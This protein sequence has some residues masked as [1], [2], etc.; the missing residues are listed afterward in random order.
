MGGFGNSIYNDFY[1]LELNYYK[2]TKYPP[3]FGRYGHT[4]TVAAGCI[5]V[6]GGE[7]IINRAK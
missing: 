6:I 5:F 2:W 1:S 7:A 3:V 4:M